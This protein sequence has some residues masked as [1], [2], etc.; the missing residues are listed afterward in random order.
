MSTPR[1]ARNMSRILSVCRNLTVSVHTTCDE[2]ESESKA[3]SPKSIR[4]LLYK[5]KRS[6]DVRKGDIR[7]QP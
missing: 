6:D 5:P 3:F 2:S 7:A 4:Y 1:I